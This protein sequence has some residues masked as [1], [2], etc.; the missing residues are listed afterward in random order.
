MSLYRKYPNQPEAACRIWKNPHHFGPALGYTLPPFA[1]LTAS[2]YSMLKS[3]LKEGILFRQTPIRDNTGASEA[4]GA[5][6]HPRY[7]VTLPWQ[8]ES[9]SHR[10]C[11]AKNGVG[12]QRLKEEQDY[13]DFE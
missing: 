6:I 4:T 10:G 3:R 9:H 1:R 7:T 5:D 11:W 2:H 13:A 8:E 12:R